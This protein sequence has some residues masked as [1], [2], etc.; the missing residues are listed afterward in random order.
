MGAGI[1]RWI[2]VTMSLCLA[3]AVTG[4]TAPPSTAPAAPP[5]IRPAAAQTPPAE[6]HPSA[7]VPQALSVWQP[8]PGSLV[9]NPVR[10]EG[11]A[12][13]ATNAVSAIVRDDLGKELGRGSTS[14]AAG[15]PPPVD[16]VLEVPFVVVAGSRAVSVEVF[17]LNATDGSVQQ[18]TRVPVR[19]E[20]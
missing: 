17:T 18:I 11:A 13:Q 9:T 19:V 5:V 12:T 3:M 4:C 15:H 8:A 7:S 1:L 14:L 6:A 20:R 10:I 16:F 2:G